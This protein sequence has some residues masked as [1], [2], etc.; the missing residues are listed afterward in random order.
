MSNPVEAIR[1]G[2]KLN[3]RVGDEQH[4]AHAVGWIAQPLW[5]YQWDHMSEMRVARVRQAWEG[6]KLPKYAVVVHAF[7]TRDKPRFHELNA[8]FCVP[9]KRTNP[10]AYESEV[11]SWPLAGWLRKVKRRWVLQTECYDVNYHVRGK[12]IQYSAGRFPTR[13]QAV[14]RART[15][16]VTKGSCD[17]RVVRIDI[18]DGREVQSSPV[19]HNTQDWGP[20][21]VA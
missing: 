10:I 6:H 7:G 18:A 2:M 16:M 17:M 21:R 15:L 13:D 1:K 19:Y 4:V 9:E 8:V 14:E 20:A 5:G 3:L 11:C 12:N